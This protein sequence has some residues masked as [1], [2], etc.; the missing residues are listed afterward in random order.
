MG[1][2]EESIDDEVR[3]LVRDLGGK[4][5]AQS[6]GFDKED[7]ISFGFSDNEDGDA[8][9]RSKAEG[10]PSQDQNFN[11]MLS[12]NLSPAFRSTPA[13]QTETPSSLFSETSSTERQQEQTGFSNP[14]IFEANSDF[15]KASIYSENSNPMFSPTFASN[16]ISPK[17]RS[18][19]ERESLHFGGIK[20]DEAAEIS[21]ESLAEEKD[22]EEDLDLQL[23]LSDNSE[24]E[25]VGDEKVE[26]SSVQN[27]IEK[28]VDQKNAEVAQK[29]TSSIGKSEKGS[30]FDQ[31]FDLEPETSRNLGD[32]KSIN[33]DQSFEIPLSEAS[34]SEEEP[35]SVPVLFTSSSPISVT[36]KPANPVIS[37]RLNS[38]IDEGDDGSESSDV[39]DVH[40]CQVCLEEFRS[41]SSLKIHRTK[42][43]KVEEQKKLK[44]KFEIPAVKVPEPKISPPKTL[45][46]SSS[47][48]SSGSDEFDQVSFHDV[49]QGC[50]A[51]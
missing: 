32:G 16:H 39:V 7:S 3:D 6:F 4:I 46:L 12:E 1:Q 24:E 23:Y 29:A 22:E 37:D 41:V 20:D 36:S 19:P 48:S 42:C 15:R 28:L 14:N 2:E 8:E 18:E 5:A 17:P 49:R 33:F 38:S 34:D 27:F 26:N 21:G 40:R 10:R 47:S 25:E 30:V 43:R 50:I 13:R 35:I 11:K 51:S 9:K 31:T 44:S 45:R